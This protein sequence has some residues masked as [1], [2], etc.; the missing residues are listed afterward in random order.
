M[1]TPVNNEARVALFQTIG[2]SKQKA[3]ETLKNA[4]VTGVLES[5]INQVKNVQLVL[6]YD[7]QYHFLLPI[8]GQGSFTGRKSN[9]KIDW[10]SPIFALDEN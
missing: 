9:N 6:F 3:E 4:D 8:L 5:T 2:L 1:A 7:N 10:K